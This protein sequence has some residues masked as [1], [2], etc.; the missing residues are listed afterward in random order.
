LYEERQDVLIPNSYESSLPNGL[1]VSVV[2]TLAVM[3]PNFF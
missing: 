3:T 1:V 2:F